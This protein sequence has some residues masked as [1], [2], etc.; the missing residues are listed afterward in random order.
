[1]YRR[2]LMKVLWGFP[3]AALFCTLLT[4]QATAQATRDYDGEWQA[5]VN[6]TESIHGNPPLDYEVKIDIKNGSFHDVFKTNQRTLDT[7]NDWLVKFSKNEVVVNIDG[8]NNQPQRWKYRLKGK[9]KS[10]S[11][12]YTEGPFFDASGLMLT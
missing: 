4:S 9:L 8:S 7:R 10:T 11:T 1:M 2:R 5:K 12:I 3:S 6:C